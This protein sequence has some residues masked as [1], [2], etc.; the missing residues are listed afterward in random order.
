LA[1][2]SPDEWDLNWDVTPII[3]DAPSNGARN[4]LQGFDMAIDIFRTPHIFFLNG[5]PGDVNSTLWEAVP[6]N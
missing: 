3:Q 2:R 4:R 6:K 5:A 1:T